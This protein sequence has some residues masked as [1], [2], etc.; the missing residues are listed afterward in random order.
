MSDLRVEGFGP[1]VRLQDSIFGFP[2]GICKGFCKG[3]GFNV[4]V[5]DG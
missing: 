3:L 2:K 4:R 1:E 5:P